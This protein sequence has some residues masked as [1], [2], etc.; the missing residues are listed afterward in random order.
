MGKTNCECKRLIGP[1]GIWSAAEL[2]GA[3]VQIGSMPVSNLAAI[4]VGSK[5]IV[6]SIDF[7]ISLDGKAI[8][9]VKLKGLDDY[10]FTLK[11]LIFVGIYQSNEKEGE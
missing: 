1:S 4:D 3:V 5:F 9:V 2:V 8:T 11:D 10:I 7:R 6:D